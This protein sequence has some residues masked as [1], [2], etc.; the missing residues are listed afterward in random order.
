M[1]QYRVVVSLSWTD[2]HRYI[3]AVSFRYA[4]HAVDMLRD[5][6]LWPIGEVV[7]H[8]IEVNCIFHG[9]T[10]ADEAGCVKC[11]DECVSSEIEAMYAGA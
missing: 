3:E 10:K 4:D 8:R 11:Y 7:S 1:S 9:W 5:G 6:E 2:M